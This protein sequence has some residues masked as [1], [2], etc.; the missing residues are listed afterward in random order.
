MTKASNTPRESR[1]TGGRIKFIAW[2]QSDVADRL[3][4]LAAER[5]AAK[6][7]TRAAVVRRIGGSLDYNADCIIQ[8]LGDEPTRMFATRME[9]VKFARANRIHLCDSRREA[10]EWTAAN[11]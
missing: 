10:R 1:R 11:C 9:A 4:K 7:P 6:L 8:F 2:K 3:D 5:A